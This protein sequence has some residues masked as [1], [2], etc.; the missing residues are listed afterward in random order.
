MDKKKFPAEL[1]SVYLQNKVDLFNEW[2]AC[3][4]DWSKVSLIFERKVS[5]SRRFKK[6]RKGMKSRDILLKYGEKTL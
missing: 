4:G 3:S 2:L 1:A 5:D 6:Q